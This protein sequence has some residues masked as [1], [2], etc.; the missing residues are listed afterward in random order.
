M[1]LSPE[2]DFGHATLNKICLIIKLSKPFI[3]S[4]P[5]VLLGGFGD[6]ANTWRWDPHV[7]LFLFPISLFLPPLSCFS[8]RRAGRRRALRAAALGRRKEAFK[9]RIGELSVLYSVDV[10]LVVAAGDGGAA[11][12]VVAWWILFGLLN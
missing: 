10:A 6:V 8:L 3:F 1:Q 2:F 12:D 7:S 5:V 11:A 4:H 9:K